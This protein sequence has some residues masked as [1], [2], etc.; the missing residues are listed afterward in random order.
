MSFIK[1]N[2]RQQKQ[3]PTQPSKRGTLLRLLRLN[4]PHTRRIALAAVCV[5][6]VNGAML[7]KPYLL[8]IVID[9]FLTQ[10]KSNI[11][12]FSLQDMGFLYFG[13]VLLSGF[14]SIAQ[15]ML[16]NRAGQEVLRSLRTQ[17][18]RTIML[19]PLRRL[20]RVSAGSLITRATNDVEA[21]SDFYT[22]VLLS[23]FQDILLVLGIFTAMLLLD[24]RI[25][26]V[27]FCVLP[28][29]FAVVFFLRKKIKS[30]FS[31]M[32]RLIGQ[33][34]GFMAESISG[35][36]LI[37]MLHGEGQMKNRFLR[38]NKQ[39]FQV[40]SFQVWLN[41][42]L[43]PASDVFANLAIALIIWYGMGRI[44]GN[45]LEIGVLY[46]FT[47]YIR[48]FFNPI[49]DLADNY[50]SIQSAF[51]SAER[52]FELLDERENTEDLALGCSLP[53]VH[54]KVEFRHVWFAYHDKDWVLRDVNFTV[55]P[56]QTAAFVGQTGAGKST[57]ISLISAFYEV[58]RGQILIDDID[59]RTIRKEDL[60]HNVTVVL[61]DVFLFSDTV[62]HNVALNDK[63]SRHTVENAV[64]SAKAQSFVDSLERG[65]DEPVME[66]GGT[67]SAGQRQLLAFARAVAH[68]PSILILD[69]ATANIDS[70]TELLIQESI[71]EISS[72]RTTLI[73]AHRLSTITTADRI[74][75]MSH[76]RIVESGKHEDLMNLHG[77][78]RNMVMQNGPVTHNDE[79]MR[80]G[81]AL[82]SDR[83]THN[84]EVAHH[85]VATQHN[86]V[87]PH[88]I[89]SGDK[90]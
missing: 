73:V 33:I 27:S 75:V 53:Q 43:K 81:M 82:Q 41:S 90:E 62:E 30:L 45:S 11:G 85:G 67:F 28:A 74:F 86:G 83:V 49:S 77:Y 57:I 50:T 31:Q 42:F 38:L 84:H 87:T 56:G 18:F 5:L 37:Q 88:A 23:L 69:E 16:I 36:W 25:A 40:T 19:L 68:N 34:N 71:H 65:L 60:R 80:N 20:D 44:S 6:L 72:Q 14:F 61:Q 66:R 13:V 29:M 24:V 21:L 1:N 12:I 22:D 32:K 10:H 76:G 26:L 54:G 64:M 7:L 47:T 9:D 79:V 46:A 51:V 48:Q 39:Y 3:H 89:S 15:A 4:A 70:Q 55:Y 58:Q 17:V 8:K 52:I 63:L 35:M 2:I 78:Y 59:I